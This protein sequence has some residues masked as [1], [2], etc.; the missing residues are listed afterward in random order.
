M[1][2]TRC[3]VDGVLTDAHFDAD[4]LSE[5][6]EDPGSVVWVDLVA[7]EADELALIGDELGLHQLAVEDVIHAHQR[8]KLDRYPIMRSCPRTPFASTRTQRS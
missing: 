3:Y 6:L 1:A 7:P 8:P 5:H 4:Q 2:R